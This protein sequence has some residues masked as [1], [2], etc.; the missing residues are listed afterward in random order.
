MESL[1]AFTPLQWVLAERADEPL[2]QPLREALGVEYV[3][4]VATCL[5]YDVSR[6]ELLHADNARLSPSV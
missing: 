3:T 2:V 5:R 6:L 4:A 1:I